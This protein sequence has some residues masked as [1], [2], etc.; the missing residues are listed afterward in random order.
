MA[1]EGFK[2]KLTAILSADVEGYSRLMGDDEE[3][4]VRTITSYRE[5][6]TTLIQQHNGKVLDSPGDNL[7]AEFVSVVDA[8]QCAVAVQKEINARNAE[9]P[10]NR[11]MQF[12]IGINL[13]DVIQ[14]EERIYGDGVNIAARLEGLSEPGGICISKT[15][16]DQIETKLPYG[17]EFLGDQTVKNIAK[18]VRAYRVLLEPEAAGKVIGEKRFLGRF[19]RK[20][21]MAAI[22]VLLMVAG[23][24][25]GWNIYLQQSKKVEPASVDK[26][27]YPLPDNP[28][29][30]VLPFVNLSEDPK[31]EYL[32]DSIT[33]QIITTL[34]RDPHLF[35]IDRQSTSVYKGK[36]VKIQQVAEELGV[37]YVLEGAVQRSGD[38]V[39]ITV[40]LIDAIKGRHIW[41]ERYDRDVKDI[42]ALQDEITIKIM[43]G[44]SIEL[45]EGEQARRWTKVGTDNLEALEK[46]YQGRGFM[47]T[48]GTKENNDK[49]IQLFK[50]AVALDPKFIWPYVYLAWS[51][52]IAARVHGWSE[53]P[54]ISLQIANDLAQKALAIDDSYDA[55][56]S[57]LADLYLQKGQYDKALSEAERAVS[58]NPNGGLAYFRL[59]AIVGQ[60]GRWEESAMYAKKAVRLNPFPGI[61]WHY[62]LGQAYFFSGQYDE[63]IRTWKKMLVKWP[64]N[65]NAYAFLAACYSSLGRDAEAAAA[66]KEVLRLNPEYSVGA[67]AKLLRFKNKADLERFNAAK[68]KAGLPE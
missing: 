62:T 45:T 34:S 56:H 35:V 17:Y 9:L 29:I 48:G 63:S 28:S 32:G 42:F 7:L 52:Y 23:V 18:P 4:T 12:R 64:D 61:W 36:P 25:I 19:S 65:I 10:E 2:R 44:L 37:R 66:A 26:M 5:V 31:Q 6:L 21:A 47:E 58:L 13:G 49:A 8:V 68:R 57:L 24:L 15:A 43:N 1:E 60:L 51:H 41:S 54:A 16:F 22:I 11:R 55:T 53:S 27:A 30:A 14:E 40:Q 38:K 50:E 3:A 67:Q 33:E 39:R 46:F 59:A 20:T